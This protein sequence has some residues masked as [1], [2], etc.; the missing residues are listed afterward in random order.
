VALGVSWYLQ[1]NEAVQLRRTCRK[2]LLGLCVVEV[3]KERLAV[4]T[5][6]AATGTCAFDKQR[7]TDEAESVCRA[8]P[9]ISGTAQEF[10]MNLYWKCS[11][12]EASTQTAT[13]ADCR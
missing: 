4:D 6:N 8:D 13:S 2:L 10:G 3:D 1:C 7:D 5:A 9:S 11:S 12:K